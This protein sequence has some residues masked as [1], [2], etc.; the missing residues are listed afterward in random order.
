MG[1]GRALLS[2]RA[3][4]HFFAERVVTAPLCRSLLLAASRRTAARIAVFPLPLRH[5]NHNN[6]DDE[7]EEEGEEH[8]LFWLR[9]LL[10]RKETD[11]LERALEE[12]SRAERACRVLVGA[13]R[14]SHSAAGRKFEIGSDVE[15][16]GESGD[17]FIFHFP[18]HT[19][20]KTH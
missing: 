14:H 10:H 2:L 4:C 6:D 1:G 8:P 19:T 3:A 13:G 11:A 20:H 16:V 9:A 12:A 18:H 15:L 7:E 17:G 5:S